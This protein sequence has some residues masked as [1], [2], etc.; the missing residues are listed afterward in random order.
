MLT[1]NSI[2][3]KFKTL[4]IAGGITAISLT[5]STSC[6]KCVTCS[7]TD[8]VGQSQNAESCKKKAN[9]NLEQ[10]LTDQWGKYGSVTC[11]SK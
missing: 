10:D 11:V 9:E 7:Y 2:K 8:D 3:M 5:S 6:K 4:I 1:K